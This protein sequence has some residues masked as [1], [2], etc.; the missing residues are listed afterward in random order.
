M[1][2]HAVRN[3]GEAMDQDR[4]WRVRGGDSARASG[5][6]ESRCISAAGV[7]AADQTSIKTNLLTVVGFPVTHKPNVVEFSQRIDH[8]RRWKR[9]SHAVAARRGAFTVLFE[10]IANDVP[11]S[12]TPY[13][14]IAS[15]LVITLAQNTVE[16]AT[17]K[18]FLK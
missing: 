8:E 4:W 18:R 2:V 16:D 3:T 7:M 12:Y 1:V 13:I 5:D 15:T 11:R 14:L 9:F 6:A 17:G 10:Q